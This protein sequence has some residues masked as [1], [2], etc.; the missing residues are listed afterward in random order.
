MSRFLNTK[1]SYA[2]VLT[3]FLGLV[4]GDHL[5]SNSL[6][7]FAAPSGVGNSCVPEP[8]QR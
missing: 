2:V 7:A 3:V 8:D 6:S 1:V 5:T 4:V